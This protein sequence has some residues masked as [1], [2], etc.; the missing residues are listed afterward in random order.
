MPY[1][2]FFSVRPHLFGIA[3]RML[4]S[5][6]EAEDIVQDCLAAGAVDES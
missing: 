2:A 1:L 5:A 4:G 6:V 3:Y